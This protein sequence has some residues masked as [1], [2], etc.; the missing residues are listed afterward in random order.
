MVE[1][2]DLADRWGYIVD[3]KGTRIKQEYT[4]ALGGKVKMTHDQA[5]QLANLVEQK[6]IQ[7]ASAGV[8]YDQIYDLW[9]N[10]RTM[11]QI[12]D[13]EKVLME[14]AKASEAAQDA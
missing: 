10:K 7:G 3:V 2:L 11:Q 8:N 1:L 14:K 12:V 13:D 4:P 9:D 6:I 5:E